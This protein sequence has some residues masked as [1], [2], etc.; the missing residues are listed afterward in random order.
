[1]RVGNEEAVDDEEAPRFGLRAS[2]PERERASEPG[3]WSLE[4]GANSRSSF[5]AATPWP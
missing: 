5:K 4:P 1:M 2:G 3:A